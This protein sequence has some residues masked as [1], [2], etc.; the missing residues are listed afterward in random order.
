MMYKQ[1]ILGMLIGVVGILGNM[2]YQCDTASK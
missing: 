2:C 1:L